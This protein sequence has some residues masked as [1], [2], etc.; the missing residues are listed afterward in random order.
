MKPH[1]E[2]IRRIMR[3][4]LHK[5][6]DDLKLVEYLISDGVIFTNAIAYHSQQAAEKYLKAFLT[7]RQITF[8][9]THDLDEL[10]DLV[11]TDNGDL[12]ASL[13]DVIVLTP[14][15]SE[16]RYPGDQ[17]DVPSDEA[18]KT[19]ELAQKVR[20]TVMKYLD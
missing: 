8:P 13:R 15:C 3:E 10:L 5:A 19:M 12:A 16:L 20:E 4:W 1:E 7:S 2:V 6:D 18:V 9:K 14:Y 11:E 17:P